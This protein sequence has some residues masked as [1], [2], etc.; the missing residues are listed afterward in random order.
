M[1]GYHEIII[2]VYGEN[3]LTSHDLNL[4]FRNDG[5]VSNF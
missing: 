4:I 2:Q 1:I 3:R 5:N